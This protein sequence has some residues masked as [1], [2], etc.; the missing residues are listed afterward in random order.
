M[1]DKR[2]RPKLFLGAIETRAVLIVLAAVGSWLII[3][4][5]SQ[6]LQRDWPF[7]FYF[8]ALLSLL[9]ILRSLSP[10]IPAF[11]G[12][13]SL[14]LC[15]LLMSLGGRLLADRLAAL[16]F[17]FLGGGVLRALLSLYHRGK[18]G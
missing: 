10:R 17:I 3:W 9:V 6:V 2:E 11:L 14:S 16:A 15:P 1:G 4:L 12:L 8:A 5:V 7:E 18:E 13:L